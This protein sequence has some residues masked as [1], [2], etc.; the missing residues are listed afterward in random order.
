[1]IEPSWEKLAGLF[2]RRASL[3]LTLCLLVVSNIGTPDTVFRIPF[4]GGSR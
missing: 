3:Q 4:S 2:A 1:V